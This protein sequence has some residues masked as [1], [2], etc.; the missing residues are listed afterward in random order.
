MKL[1]FFPMFQCIIMF[2]MLT[3]SAASIYPYSPYAYAAAPYV[4][5]PASAAYVAHHPYVAPYQYGEYPVQC[6]WIVM[7]CPIGETSITATIDFRYT[8]YSRRGFVQLEIGHD[9]AA[10]GVPSI[11]LWSTVCSVRLCRTSIIIFQ[12]SSCWQF[13]ST[14]I[15]R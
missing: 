2:A 7:I 12:S 8:R 13:S 3:V 6:R 1:F 9:Q 11:S 5:Y 10:I 15:P 14:I 4:S